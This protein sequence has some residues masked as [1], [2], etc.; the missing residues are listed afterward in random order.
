MDF[1][2][3][4]DIE[5]FNYDECYAE[6]KESIKKPNI[7]VC[8]GSG[9]GKS[10]LINDIFDLSVDERAAVGIDGAPQTRGVHLFSSEN[11][12]INL[13]DTEGYEIGVS[14][15]I[16][17]DYYFRNIIGTID[18]R[19]KEY[20]DKMEMHIHEVWYCIN[21]RFCDIDKN[22]VNYALSKNVPVVVVITKVDT[23]DEDE[24][25]QIKRAIHEKVS[26]VEV[27][28]YATA[29]HFPSEI[30]GYEKYVQKTELINWALENLDDTLRTGFIPS[31]KAGLKEKRQ[32]IL[33][34]KVPFYSTLA[35]SAVVGMSVVNVP[36]ADSIPL[37]GIQVKMAMDIIKT[38]GIDNSLKNVISDLVGANLLSYLG[39]TIASQLLSVIP[40]VGNIVKGTVNVSVAVT[41]TAVLGTAISIICEQYLK[42]CIENGGSENLPK[43][44]D[45]I[46]ADRLEEVMK[47]VANDKEKYGIDKTIIAS[48]KAAENKKRTK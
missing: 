15:S 41:I 36:F 30:E 9:V 33:T 40:V 16:D 48:K 42:A 13:F 25:V 23:L 8:G 27:F 19:L 38:Y 29:E 20:P 37:M 45:F 5:N 12:T 14:D 24:L 34:H 10:S 2:S 31:L 22:V 1:E 44:S 3:R 26:G 43:F 17:N 6:L 35:G 11:S 28:T 21:N 46:T 7:L 47:I 18:K 39:K 4:F 32:Y